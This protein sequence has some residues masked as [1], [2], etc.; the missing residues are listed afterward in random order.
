MSHTNPHELFLA[1][2]PSEAAVGDDD[3]D[4]EPE[5]VDEPIAENG[6]LKTAKTD[7]KT[8]LTLL[9]YMPKMEP[10]T[11]VANINSNRNQTI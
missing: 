3:E 9:K 2:E 5:I 11:N 4:E 6:E 1:A 7:A 8:S 10:D